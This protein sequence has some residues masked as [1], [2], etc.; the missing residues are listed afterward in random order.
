[1]AQLDYF[2]D[3]TLGFDYI[4]IGSN[5][6]TMHNDGQ[7]A[8]L[9][10]I[11]IN[12]PI[13]FNR[14]NAQLREKEAKLEVSKKNYDNLENRVAFEVEDLFFKITTYQDIVSLYKTALIPQTEQTFQAAKTAYE[15]GKVDFLNWL[16]AE[17]MLLQTRLAYYKAVVDYRKSIAYLERVVGTDL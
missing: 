14:L 15:T 17:R 5:H 1:L 7:D 9:G 8:W 16:D 13:W 6:T 3:F 11:M 12:V 2:P 4:Q 10:K